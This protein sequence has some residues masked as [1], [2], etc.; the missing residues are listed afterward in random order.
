MVV[1][2]SQVDVSISED[3]QCRRQRLADAAE[4]GDGHQL[5]QLL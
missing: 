5:I 2:G 4:P 3:T 1:E